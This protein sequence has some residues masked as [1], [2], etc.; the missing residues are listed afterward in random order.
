[1]I[2]LL[3]KY[4]GKAPRYTSYPTANHFNS[5]VNE[6]VYRQWLLKFKE[7]E[8]VS[9]YIHIPYCQKLC[10]FCGCNTK[11]VNRYKPVQAYIQRLEKEIE[12]IAEILP[13]KL[14]A[15]HLH[16]G[17]GSPNILHHEDFSRLMRILHQ[18]FTIEKNAE[19][20]LE[21]DPR[22]VS[23]EDI[24]HYA[25]EGVTRISFG[26][27]DTNPKVQHA[28][29]RIQPYERIK[30]VVGYCRSQRIR[31]INFD[32]IYGLPYQTPESITDTV[33]LISEL[34]PNRISFFGYA[35]V[36]LMKRHQRL[37]DEESLPD[38]QLRF[39]L[40]QRGTA[41]LLQKGYSQVGL[42]H[43]ALPDDEIVVAHDEKKLQRNFQGYTTDTALTLLAFGASAISRTADGYVQNAGNLKDYMDAIDHHRLPVARGIQI[44]EEDRIRRRVIEDLMCYLEVDLKLILSNY[45]IPLC[46]FSD[47]LERLKKMEEDGVLMIKDYTIMIPK[48]NRTFVRSVCAL[49][50][51]YLPMKNAYHSSTI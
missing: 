35:H 24:V 42:D 3:K 14:I 9:L 20:A 26:I 17:G 21:V 25:K 39:E 34:H 29:N 46:F 30:E 40:C 15:Q 7:G 44:T 1:M 45:K 50:D 12:T 18:K 31:K 4:H 33:D 11:I 27:Q 49:F 32:L 37:L 16:F 28:I 5:T 10:W 48:E 19:I 43:F 22:T 38:S 23:E 2:S 6:E 41:R 36:P 47:E 51:S 13:E 8:K